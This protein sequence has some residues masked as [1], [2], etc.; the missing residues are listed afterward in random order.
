MYLSNSAWS[1]VFLLAWNLTT[2][3][4]IS[5]AVNFFNSP[6]KLQV[7]VSNVD[8]WVPT[9]LSVV[10]HGDLTTGEGVLVDLLGDLLDCVVQENGRGVIGGRHLCLRALQGWEESGV[11]QSWLGELQLVS[12][13]SAHS[14]VWVLIDGTWN[15]TWGLR[16]QA[17]D[18]WEGGW[19]SGGDL[20][21]G[22]MQLTDTVRVLEPKD[23]SGSGCVG[24]DERVF[25][26]ETNGDDV[27]G[28]FLSEGSDVFDGELWLEEELLVIGQLD[29]QRSIKD[30]LQPFGEDE[31]NQVAQMHT[32]GGRPSP[33]VKEE[34]LA[35]FVQI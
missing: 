8:V 18:I 16:W 5:S 29:N 7:L 26:V 30:V 34:L 19:E 9:E 11:D 15:Q 24:E 22:E 2:N 14:E 23:G 25:R 4:A 21:G 10:L 35:V 1:T 17:Q 28:V 3:L 27:L 31:R 32:V 13:V 20:D 6:E 12:N 33:G